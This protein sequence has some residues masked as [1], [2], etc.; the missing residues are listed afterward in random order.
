M[1]NRNENSYNR[2]RL[3]DTAELIMK[4]LMTL[5]S[6]ALIATVNFWSNIKDHVC[7]R[8]MIFFA[9]GLTAI[10]M[11]IV[12]YY[13]TFKIEKFNFWKN[14]TYVLASLCAIGSGVSFLW[15]VWIVRLS[16]Q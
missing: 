4:S 16:A 12:F 10:L 2:D 1:L 15:G 14:T 13:L 5:N 9:T 3:N 7:A 8:P 6:G 11:F